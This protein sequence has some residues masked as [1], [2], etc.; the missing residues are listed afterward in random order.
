MSEERDSIGI[1]SIH[2]G[3]RDVSDTPDEKTKEEKTDYDKE[4]KS[5]ENLQFKEDIEARKSYANK[6]FV[7]I[8][9]WLSFMILIVMIH[10]FGHD[11]SWFQLSDTVLVT[12]ITTTTGSVL[13][14]FT[15]IVNYLFKTK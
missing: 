12:L 6:M 13:G 4:R 11:K 9:V 14:L 8:S 3:R 7:M 10:G 1:E 5:L 15:I 2:V